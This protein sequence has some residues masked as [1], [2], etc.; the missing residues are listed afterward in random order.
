MHSASVICFVELAFLL[1]PNKRRKGRETIPRPFKATCNASPTA[2]GYFSAPWHFLY[3]F[4]LP[5]GQGSLRPTFSP[6]RRC[7]VWLDSP[8]PAI[9][10]ASSSRCFLRWNSFSR[11][12]IVV[13]GWRVE[14]PISRGS[15]SIVR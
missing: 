12:S 13:D 7:T 10:A 9:L 2:G 8:A 1:F 11:A 5:Q 3:F 15:A 6:V 4:P 14:I